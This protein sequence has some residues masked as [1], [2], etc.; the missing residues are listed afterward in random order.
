MK[1]KLKRICLIAS[2]FSIFANSIVSASS[3][4][5][6]ASQTSEGAI[7]TQVSMESTSFDQDHSFEKIISQLSEKD[8]YH[9]FVSFK[10]KD[11][12]TLLKTCSEEERF[13]LYGMFQYGTYEY[14]FNQKLKKND[15]KDI[16]QTIHQILSAFHKE[17]FKKT[18]YGEET[19]L[20]VLNQKGKTSY[21]SLS[22]YRSYLTSG[23]EAAQIWNLFEQLP[24][25]YPTIQQIQKTLTSIFFKNSPTKTKKSL[26]SKQKYKTS[27]IFVQSA[28]SGDYTAT[29]VGSDKT[30]TTGQIKIF[31]TDDMSG[32]TT[33]G[34][35]T[36]SRKN[37]PSWDTMSNSPTTWNCKLTVPDS[38]NY[39]DL[40]LD[41]TTVTTVKDIYGYYFI[42]NF[43]LKLT[44]H[45]YYIYSKQKHDGSGNGF[46][47]NF[48]SYTQDNDGP[49]T[50]VDG[51]VKKDT[52]RTVNWQL[53]AAALG[54]RTFH[55]M[56]YTNCKS[57]LTY[58]RPSHTVTVNPNG[59]IYAGTTSHTIHKGRTG[60]W[61]TL[62]EIPE[63]DYFLFHGFL[64]KGSSYIYRSAGTGTTTDI[65]SA[66][67][68]SIFDNDH[69]TRYK[70]T[71]V[72]NKDY[73]R[74]HTFSVPK[75]NTIRIT[76]Y[77]RIN[78]LS[79]D[80]SISLY[81]KESESE[82]RASSA[83]FD[84]AD[85]IW[86]KF[87]IT[88]T[89]H[90]SANHALLEIKPDSSSDKVQFDLKN[91]IF[92][93]QT[94]H[95]RIADTDLQLSD[96]K[97]A[98]VLLTAQWTPLQYKINY[99]T[100][101][102]NTNETISS[103]IQDQDTSVALKKCTLQMDHASFSGWKYKDTIY[104]ENSIISYKDLVDTPLQS[105]KSDAD[106]TPEQIE[107]EDTF[108]F[109]AVWNYAP[110]ITLKPD[111]VVY[112]E[113]EEIKT[114]QL[115]E[116]I[117][118]C[119]DKED[120][121]LTKQ[122]YIKEIKYNSSKDGYQPKTQTEFS[123][124]TVIDTYF[125]HLR[126]GE[127]VTASVTYAV[128]DSEHH[129]S[130]A[131]KE[132]IIQYNNPPEIKAADLSF[133]QD[134]FVSD[135]QQVKKAIIDNAEAFDMEDQNKNLDL[136]VKIIEPNPLDLSKMKEPGIY[137]VTYYVKDSLKKET[138]TPVK[139]YVVNADP[140]ASMRKQT[141]RFISKNYLYTLDNASV[142]KTN[143]SYY[144]YLKKSLDKSGKQANNTYTFTSGTQS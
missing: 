73:L 98:D 10:K 77:L 129:T 136:H 113:G 62:K 69:F 2:V 112:T 119:I 80:N 87:D 38:E 83:S 59:G 140:Y 58:T 128:A 1:K 124:D 114:S 6:T 55:E 137:S 90:T 107:K 131:Q 26:N 142:W 78:S 65:S 101:I 41:Q 144:D 125:K 123:T 67:Q 72:S 50:I 76:G 68:Q 66:F 64:R 31:I 126:K 93:D 60:N 44:Q 117:Q 53:N 3:I 52:V 84:K 127:T 95:Q 111:S 63:K 96:G 99:D 14:L 138:K 21:T 12:E 143:S 103:Q 46:R 17:P 45:A 28:S 51:I 30:Y 120:G 43:K 33:T 24:S 36:V 75:G 132:I 74:F 19:L 4:E 85:G 16:S 48:E 39:H 47:L 11:L 122:V 91:I 42:M 34:T 29:N 18:K 86:K 70:G 105:R 71:N 92:T 94:T 89:Y 7:S 61:I 35:L 79:S 97:D 104:K 116:L 23:H 20:Q 37:A 5:S 82:T 27:P 106:I 13:V 40:V 49:G 121:D 88:R 130:T 118:Q 100:G 56:K 108:T 133:Y 135:P 134:E 81:E 22:E 102:A 139:I 32:K 54:L 57:Y 9:S 141:I 115:L 109:T 25:S 8:F 15:L 110:V